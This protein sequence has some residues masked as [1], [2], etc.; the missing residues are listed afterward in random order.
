MQRLLTIT[1]RLLVTL[2]LM[3]A[4]YGHATTVSGTFKYNG[5]PFNGSVVVTLIYPG[6]TGTYLNMPVPS[7]PVPIVNG[8]LSSFDVDGNDI[9]LPRKTYYKFEFYDTYG[10]LAT[11]LNYYVSGS[12]F[13]VGTAVPTPVLTNN[14]NFLDLLGLRSLSVQNL[15]LYNS[16][17]LGNTVVSSTGITS[18][19]VNGVYSSAVYNTANPSSTTCGIQEALNDMPSTGAT[20]LLQVGGCSP[21]STATVTKPVHIMGHGGG[22]YTDNTTFTTTNASTFFTLPAGVP[23]LS[24]YPTSGTLSG[25]TI[26]GFLVKGGGYLA[27]IGNGSVNTAFT[28]RVTVRDVFV[29]AS[30]DCG[31]KVP[32]NVSGL[33]ITDSTFTKSVGTGVCFTAPATYSVSGVVLDHV[34]SSRNGLD[35]MGIDSAATQDVTSI[36]SSFDNNVRYGMTTAAGS[37]SAFYRSVSSTYRGNVR[38]MV[39]ADGTGSSE[40]DDFSPQGT[41]A[42]G[43]YF[44]TPTSTNTTFTFKDTVWGGNAVVDIFT[45]ANTYR[46]FAY[47]GKTQPTNTQTVAGTIIFLFSGSAVALN[48][49]TTSV[50]ISGGGATCGNGT[51][52]TAATGNW[53][54]DWQGVYHQQVTGKQQTDCSDSP[55]NGKEVITL[56]HACP[57][58]I[59]RV[60]VSNLAPVVASDDTHQAS[61]SLVGTTTTT[62]STQRY[63]SA[64][65]GGSDSS[66]YVTIDCY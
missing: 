24:V 17:T 61:Q 11:R 39:I 25:I 31:V 15:I 21:T 47:P 27:D 14:I 10:N 13:D 62:V 42:Y 36:S 57:T 8:A 44:D 63:R 7:G 19:Q 46:I 29:Y 30:S 3:F 65:H 38:G 33:H 60:N 51:F 4:V 58:A 26:E 18:P 55:N 1:L 28:N 53:Y 56:P 22:G 20:L 59:I 32:G 12:T 37:T 66:P 23:L 35:G 40:S 43:A 41:Q 6:T 16:L 2:A 50:T 5:S 52:A 34:T 48:A 45:G 9:M 49:T 54:Q 64:D